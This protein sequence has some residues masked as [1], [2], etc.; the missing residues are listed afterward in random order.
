MDTL[1]PSLVALLEVMTVRETILF[2]SFEVN[3]DAAL[4]FLEADTDLFGS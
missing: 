3:F 2:K 4:K 1:R